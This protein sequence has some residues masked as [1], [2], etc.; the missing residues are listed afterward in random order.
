MYLF[1]IIS[2][3]ILY[4]SKLLIDCILKDFTT[5]KKKDTVIML[6]DRGLA[7]TMVVI[8]LL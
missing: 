7:N 4:T 6:H 1:I 5:Q 2:N 8:I 3:T